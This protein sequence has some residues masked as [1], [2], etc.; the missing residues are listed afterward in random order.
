M[1]DSEIE[2]IGK[3]GFVIGRYYLFGLDMNIVDYDGRIVL[4][5]VVAEG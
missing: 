2:L 3:F 5:V 1:R 4:Y